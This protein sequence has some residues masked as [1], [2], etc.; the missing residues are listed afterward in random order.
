[1]AASIPPEIHGQKYLSLATF[2]KTGALVYT[3]I[4]FAEQ[5]GRLYF[6]TSSKSGKFKRIR[7]NPSVKIGPCTMPGIF[8][9]GPHPA[10]VGF[11]A[12]ARHSQRQV[13]GGENP[14]YL[15]QHRRIFGNYPAI[16]IC[17]SLLDVSQVTSIWFLATF[18]LAR[19]ACYHHG[20]SW[21]S[22]HS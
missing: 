12:H 18:T 10:R 17:L 20:L 13:L 14:S 5:D 15:V 7:N 3:P 21:F 22:Q 2:R 16:L 11:P 6:M 19:F 8:G 4:W 1:M 9:H